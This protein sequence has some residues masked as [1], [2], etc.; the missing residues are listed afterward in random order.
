MRLFLHIGT[1]KT[2][3]SFLQTLSK[4]GR[5]YLC[6]QGIYFPQGTRYDERCMGA[7]RISAGNGRMLAQ[8]T[9][10]GKWNDLASKLKDAREKATAQG[11]HG[12]LLSSELMLAPLSADTNLKAWHT[13]MSDTGF[14]AMQILVV[15]RDPAGQFLSLYKHRAKRGTAGEISSWSKVGYDLPVTLAAL[16]HGVTES[17]VTL[18]AR[19]YDR[20]EGALERIFFHDWLGIAPP[21]IDLPTTINPSLALS[22]LALLRALAERRPDIVVPLYEHLVTLEP[23]KKAQGEALETHARAVADHAVAAH[24]DEWTAWNALLPEGEALAIPNPAG[25]IPQEP[26]EMGFSRAQIE[27]LM[28]F[29]GRSATP[30]FLL[31][32]LW[33]SHIRPVLGRAKRA[34]LGSDIT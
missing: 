17:G 12:V 8:I 25:D 2:G 22:E 9:E 27:E 11:C 32:L 20:A 26:R 7:G 6:Q 28:E 14:K 19:R 5:E 4:R 21:R 15:L 3:S 31:Q 29:L 16:R 18:T 24:R 23:I 1:E 34:T 13:I 30:R 10:L 33:V